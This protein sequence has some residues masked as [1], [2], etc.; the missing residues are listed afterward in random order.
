MMK[1]Q[2]CSY[3]LMALCKSIIIIIIIIIIIHT[4]WVRQGMLTDNLL[5]TLLHLCN[6][7]A[8]FSKSI[9]CNKCAAFLN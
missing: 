4:D 2:R 1:F 3:D 8:S 6:F 7:I 5:Q 9:L